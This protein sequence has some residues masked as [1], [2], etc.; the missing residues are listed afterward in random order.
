MR[1]HR[2]RAPVATLALLLTV[3][4]CSSAA[5]D[6]AERIVE[7]LALAPGA[8]VADVGAGDGRW[9][10]EIARRVGP[11]GR[12]F[13][14]EIEAEMLEKI[15]KRARNDMLANVTAVLG[16]QEST[17]LPDGCCDAA[18]LRLV[19]HHF[20]DPEVMR[21]SLWRALRPGG[22]LAIIDIVPQESWRELPGVPD[23]GGHGVTPDEVVA[24]LESSGF[25]L[26]S[27]RS[28]WNG[29]P[30]RYALLFVRP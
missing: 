21:A 1:P 11:E 14:T 17:G 27:R 4:S 30:D 26:L 5:A 24:D 10:V 7:L 20:E 18:L 29:D 6:E 2:R 23:R 12:V 16:D 25:E 15:E 13:A 22:R 19:Y 28:E 8:E 3:A 9:A